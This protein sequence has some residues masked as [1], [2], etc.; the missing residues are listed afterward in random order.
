VVDSDEY[1]GEDA[2]PGDK[3][4]T[5]A[6]CDRILWTGKGLRQLNYVTVNSQLSDHRPVTAKV[7]A[8]VEAISQAKLKRTCRPRRV[9]KNGRK[10]CKS[11]D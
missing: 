11:F 2:K 7:I 9:S 1:Y 8:D 4:R 6:W 10:R 5:P 3:R